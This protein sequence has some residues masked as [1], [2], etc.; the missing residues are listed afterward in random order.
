MKVFNKHERRISVPADDLGSVLDS[1]SGPNDRLW[2]WE[3]WPP[4]RFDSPL[5]NGSSGG[6]GPIRYH[7]SEYVPGQRITFQFVHSGLVGGLYGRHYFEIISMSN[8]ALIRHVVDAEC[9][10]KM[11][12]KWLILVGPLHDALIEDAFD[13]V[14]NNLTNGAI[15]QHQWSPWVKFLRSMLAR[16][17][18]K[19]S[20]HSSPIVA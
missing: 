17:R 11:W 13:K 15:K 3:T 14:E 2:P 19:E 4:M 5:G 16:K 6:H 8:Q 10:F 9:D 12:T 7:V 1:L 18:R 20:Q